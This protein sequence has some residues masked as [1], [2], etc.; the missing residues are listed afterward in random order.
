MW[1]EKRG[2][3]CLGAGPGGQR[4]RPSLSVYLSH[5]QVT[6]I[7]TFDSVAMHEWHV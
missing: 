2:L 5:P 7:P 4:V 1:S 3:R 6:L